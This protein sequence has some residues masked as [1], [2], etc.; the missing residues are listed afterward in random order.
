MVTA[1]IVVASVLVGYFILECAVEVLSEVEG[2]RWYRRRL[3][4]QSY[5]LAMRQLADARR[6]IHA[7]FRDAEHQMDMAARR[8]DPYRIGKWSDF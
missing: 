6:K 3:M 2:S 4:I 5:K 8:Q 1:V 7:V